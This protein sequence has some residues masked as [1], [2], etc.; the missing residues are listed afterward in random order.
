M[1][2]SSKLEDKKSHGHDDGDDDGD[3]IAADMCKYDSPLADLDREYT[4][5]QQQKKNLNKKPANG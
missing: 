2:Q 4:N 1:F 5:N 3:V